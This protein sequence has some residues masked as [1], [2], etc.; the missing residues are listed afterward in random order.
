MT[1][2]ALSVRPYPPLITL[3]AGA[4]FAELAHVHRVL[5]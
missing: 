5:P 3:I 2:R 1:W 4:G